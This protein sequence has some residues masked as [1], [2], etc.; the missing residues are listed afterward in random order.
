M[1]S[2][3]SDKVEVAR[4][5]VSAWYSSPSSA[6]FGH[7]PESYDQIRAGARGVVVGLFEDEPG[8]RVVLVLVEPGKNGCNGIRE[9][10]L[11]PLSPAPR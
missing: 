7:A 2:K 9:T 6:V 8:Q 11:A 10:D 4:D 3:I 1:R 5:I